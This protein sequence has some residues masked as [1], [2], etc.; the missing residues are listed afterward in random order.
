MNNFFLI[1]II[2]NS[3][4]I[5][6]LIITQIISYPSLSSIDKS[7][8]EK[9]HKNYVNKISYVVIPFMLI[10]LF[11]LLYLTYYKSDLFMIKSLL[12]LM[13]IWLFTFICIVPL[14]NS[15]SNKRSVDN[16]NSLINYNWFRTILWTIKL[17]IILFVYL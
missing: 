13:T 3:I 11:S 10:E 6:I 7:Y 2:T 14:H 16:I 17:V 8:F 5:G 4:L 15:L 12:I 1:Q 9:Y